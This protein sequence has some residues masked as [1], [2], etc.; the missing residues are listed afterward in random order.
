MLAS[1]IFAWHDF[2][3]QA[4]F[5]FDF[6]SPLWSVVGNAVYLSHF[7]LPA[8]L[9]TACALLFV[10]YFHQIRHSARVRD[11]ILA[12]VHDGVG[13]RL[14]VLLMGLE[15]NALDWGAVKEDVR[16]CIDELRFV[17]L[18]EGEK[19]SFLLELISSF[20]A[21]LQLRLQKKEISFQY[22]INSAA[23]EVLTPRMALVLYFA[24]LECLSNVMKHARGCAKTV[25]CVVSVVDDRVCLKVDDD[26]PGIRG[27]RND[28]QKF[29]GVDL[30]YGLGVRSLIARVSGV[31]GDIRIVC[32]ANGSTHVEIALPIATI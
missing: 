30:T 24:V 16:R 2:A 17:L 10:D 13:A 20:C 28:L 29:D 19:S 11:E 9:L 7:S 31:N 12:D 32:G 27:W 4:G 3:V 5:V 14:N 22:E 8:F 25:Q 1:A 18:P 6:D 26:G 21:T 23:A 15:L